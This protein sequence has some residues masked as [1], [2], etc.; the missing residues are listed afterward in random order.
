M[1]DIPWTADQLTEGIHRALKA[2]DMEGVTAFLRLL[3]A[4]DPDRAEGVHDAI[5]A[6]LTMRSTP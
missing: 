5:Q 6:G 3:V 4:V 1:A 2:Q